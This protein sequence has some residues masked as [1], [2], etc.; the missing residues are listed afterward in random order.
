MTL[1]LKTPGKLPQLHEQVLVY[2]AGNTGRTLID[3]LGKLGIE[4]LAFIDKNKNGRMDYCGFRLLAL[5]EIEKSLL[6]KQVIISIHNRG[7]NLVEI[8]Q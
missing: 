6:S 7:V 2:G 5:D 8:I 3:G 4:V 1:V